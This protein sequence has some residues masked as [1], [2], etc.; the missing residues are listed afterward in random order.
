MLLMT[1]TLQ[2][3]AVTE[4][5][6]SGGNPRMEVFGLSNPLLKLKETKRTKFM[7]FHCKAWIK[8][9]KK[10]FIHNSLPLVFQ[11]F[12]YL[13]INSDSVYI[14]GFGF[15]E[16]LYQ[17][18]HLLQK[19]KEVMERIQRV[20]M[21]VKVNGCKEVTSWES[22]STKQKHFIRRTFFTRRTFLSS[23]YANGS[24]A[25]RMVSTVVVNFTF[26]I[27]MAVMTH[28]QKCISKTQCLLEVFFL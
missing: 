8:E 16:Q 18:R 7:R 1:C 25:L 27:I 20:S 4:M 28:Q 24:K 15:C 23:R 12:C 26:F 14:K 13:S 3:H 22:M 6:L 5:L 21:F 10:H 9:K 19:W 11:G 17:T 2:Q